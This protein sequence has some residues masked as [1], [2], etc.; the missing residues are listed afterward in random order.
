MNKI[1]KIA[2]A[3]ATLCL[4]SPIICLVEVDAKEIY[5]YITTDVQSF[6]IN[7]ANIDYDNVIYM[8]KIESCE[9]LDFINTFNSNN[10]VIANDLVLNSISDN[11]R[12][13]LKEKIESGIPL[14]VSGD[15]GALQHIGISVITNPNASYSAIYCDP[16]SNMIY[17]YGIESSD[18]NAEKIAM[19]WVDSVKT[20]TILESDTDYG[21]AIFYQETKICDG[22]R[23]RINA[24]ALYSKLGTSNGYTYYSIQYTLSH[25]S[26]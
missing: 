6:E 13:V 16:T 12:V 3:I 11:N 14:I 7:D 5:S 15:S 8:D 9:S 17:C 21:N 24:T 4:A 10:V 19:A 22:D 1:T 20:A 25:N 18:D 26:R 2:I 23:A